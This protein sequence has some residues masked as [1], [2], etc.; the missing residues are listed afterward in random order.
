MIVDEF[1]GFACHGFTIHIGEFK[2]S[3]AIFDGDDVGN[4]TTATGA[5]ETDGSDSGPKGIGSP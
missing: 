3:V 4:V 2:V 1:T 5:R